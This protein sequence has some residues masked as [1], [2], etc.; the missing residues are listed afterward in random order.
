L[1]IYSDKNYIKVGEEV[2]ERRSVVKNVSTVKK[3]EPP[4]KKGVRGFFDRVFK[5]KEKK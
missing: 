5:K 3:A 4:K 1:C 2:T